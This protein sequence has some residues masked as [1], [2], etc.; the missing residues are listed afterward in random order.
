MAKSKLAALGNAKTRNLVLVVGGVILVMIIYTVSQLLG[1]D[2]IDG[3]QE[4]KAAGVPAA[5][6][7][8]GVNTSPEFT[9]LV[10]EQNIKRADEAEK[11]KGSSIPTI[12]DSTGG[13]DGAG[14]FGP[15]FGPGG[16][17]FGQGGAGG[18]GGFGGAGGAGG[19][20]GGFGQGG[21][22]G[23]LF[24]GQGGDADGKTAAQLREERLARQRAE[25]E[26]R[27]AAA[28]R[29]KELERLRKLAEAER[30]KYQQ[31]VQQR[32]A[33]MESQANSLANTWLTVTPQVL[34]QGSLAAIEYQ[35]DEN[36]NNDSV[37]SSNGPVVIGK[38]EDGNPVFAPK[39]EKTFIKAGTILYGI[40]NT[41]INT[42]EQG[43]ILATIVHG[44]L[45]GARLVGS[46]NFPGN[47]AEAVILNFNTMSVPYLNNSISINAV[48]VD[49]DTARTALA[50]DVDHHYLL[51]YG[52]LFAASFMQGYGQAIS[53]AGG[54]VT[55]SPNGTTQETK[56]ELSGSE[57]FYAALGTVG[58]EWANAVRPLFDTPNTVTVDQSI[59]I[60]L[61]FLSDVDITP[62]EG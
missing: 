23:S 17:G 6:G 21:A 50:S 62:S 9:K 31:T 1:G 27:R 52:S 28:E 30:Q 22:G 13:A 16:A 40:L 47:R 58:E 46:I 34:V 37:N 8:P 5:K 18:A 42:D 41:A 45:K 48:A 60:G 24:G 14:A 39:E 43:P 29:R 53:E 20:G 51:R 11:K 19:A 10:Q 49:Q 44:K 4:S 25:I 3:G 15:G 54:T 26:R 61:L 57:E 56:P 38:D 35:E 33:I 32:A 59:G 12:Y 55:T 2:E 36:A 7:I